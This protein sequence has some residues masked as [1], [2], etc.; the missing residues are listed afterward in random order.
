MEI[1]RSQQ[2]ILRRTASGEKGTRKVCC[3]GIQVKNM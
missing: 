2:K 3:L 1:R